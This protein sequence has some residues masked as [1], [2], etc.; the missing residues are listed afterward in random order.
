M[1]FLN[2]E[3][4]KLI[5][6]N[7]HKNLAFTFTDDMY[8]NRLN[9]KRSIGFTLAEVLITLGIIGVVAAMTMPTLINNK[10]NKELETAFKKSHTIIAQTVIRTIN[11]DYG[12]IA[13][14]INNQT[15]LNEFMKN[16]Q[17]YTIKS[18]TCDFGKP[19]S[20]AIFPIS[21]GSAFQTFLQSNYKTYNGKTPGIL[22]NDGIMALNDG[23]FW[24]FDWAMGSEAVYQKTLICVDTNGWRKKPN[25]Y[26]HDFFIFQV[27]ENG[28]LLPMG[29][30]GTTYSD[31][32]NCSITSNS[33]NNGYGCTAKAISDPN[34]F[35]NLP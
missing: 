15:S 35:K 9:N 17:K 27:N 4:N 10:Q 32:S 2:R 22:C 30:N 31:A 16:L 14:T 28:Q 29:S 13:P 12:G 11:E 7:K 25:K 24:F 6:L 20:T 26:G 23:S 3:G 1:R 21:T 8:A 5:T 18:E 33:S 19:C 34:Y